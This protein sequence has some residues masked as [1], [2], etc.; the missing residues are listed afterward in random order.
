VLYVATV[1]DL[2]HMVYLKTFR[3]G[4]FVMLP[5][6]PMDSY[7]SIIEPYSSI[8]VM[9]YGSDPNVT[10]SLL[11]DNDLFKYVLNRVPVLLA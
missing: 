7:P 10:A 6:S 4:S 1:P 11:I 9:H 3:Y 8:A 5:N 2:A